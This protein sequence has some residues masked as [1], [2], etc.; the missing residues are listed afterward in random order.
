MGDLRGDNHD[1][2]CD[3]AFHFV[4]SFCLSLAHGLRIQAF[5]S[6]GDSGRLR[7]QPTPDDSGR[8]RMTTNDSG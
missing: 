2:A 4:M 5:V 8:L 6:K 1:S 7:P 3:Q